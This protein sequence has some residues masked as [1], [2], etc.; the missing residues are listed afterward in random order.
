MKG[1][2]KPRDVAVQ[3]KQVQCLTKLLECQGIKERIGPY[4]IHVAIKNG[5]Q[6]ALQVMLEEG[7]NV[8]EQ[9]KVRKIQNHSLFFIINTR[10]YEQLGFTAL[11]YAI[12]FDNIPLVKYCLDQ[13]ADVNCQ[14]RVSAHC[15]CTSTE[16]LLHYKYF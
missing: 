4:P 2:Y 14:S 1:G 11:H 15:L 10:L 9:S 12:Y 8:D 6:E 13:N 7:F 16:L 3:K 5:D